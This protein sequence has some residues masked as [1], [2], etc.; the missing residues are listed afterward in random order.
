VLRRLLELVTIYGDGVAIPV[1]QSDL[2]GLAG[3][4]RATVNR[5][6][7]QEQSRG[8]IKVER[9]RVVVADRAGLEERAGPSG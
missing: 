2:A 1:T 5:V 4:S 9:A 3:T 6:L 8:R 7:R